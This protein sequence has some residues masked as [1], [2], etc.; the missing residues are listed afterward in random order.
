M[1]GRALGGGLAGSLRVAT[2][3]AAGAG[4]AGG[5]AAGAVVLEDDAAGGLDDATDDAYRPPPSPLPPTFLADAALATAFPAEN[6][7]RARRTPPHARSH[8]P[9]PGRKSESVHGALRRS[10]S[11]KGRP[12]RCCVSLSLS[13]SLSLWAGNWRWR[14]QAAYSVYDPVL[15]DILDVNPREF[16]VPGLLPDSHACL[17]RSPRYPRA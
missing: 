2:G 5:A 15:F 1:L 6:R 13:L 17:W 11:H 14:G 7:V 8:L 16:A 3:A 4:G 9:A 12:N 10:A